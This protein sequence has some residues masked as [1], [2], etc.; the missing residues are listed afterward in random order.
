MAMNLIDQPI[1]TIDDNQTLRAKRG[2]RQLWESDKGHWGVVEIVDNKYSIILECRHREEVA[3]FV[4][5]HYP[6]H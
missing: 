4:F 1:G 3:R 6:G 5:E 2:N